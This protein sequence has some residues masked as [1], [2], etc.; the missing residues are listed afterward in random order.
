MLSIRRYKAHLAPEDGSL[1][2]LK[3]GVCKSCRIH[4]NLFS[5][6]WQRN[7]LISLARLSY[8]PSI[9]GSRGGCGGLCELLDPVVARGIGFRV[10][11]LVSDPWV[12]VQ[13]QRCILESGMHSP[14]P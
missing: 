6:F 3:P 1:T 10:L 4:W 14:E 7:E 12:W 8:L 9:S 11:D 13:R 2:C 5:S